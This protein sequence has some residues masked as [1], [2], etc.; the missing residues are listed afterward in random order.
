[1]DNPLRIWNVI[2]ELN[3]HAAGALL[4][5]KPRRT[6]HGPTVEVS[7][8]KPGSVLSKRQDPSGTHGVGDEQCRFSTPQILSRGELE[9]L[10]GHAL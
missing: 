6:R 2:V 1:M 8:M 5:G 3:P 10:N 9:L 7:D 4:K